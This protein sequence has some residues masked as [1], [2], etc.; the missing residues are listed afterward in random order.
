VFFEPNRTPYDLAWRMFG[1]PIRVHP[2]FWLISAA[3]GWNLMEQGF[4]FLLLW[5]ACVFV[6]VLVHELGH[7][8]LGRLFGSQGQIVLYSFG[9]LAIG[10][11]RLRARW[12]RI[13]VYLA[14][15]LAGFGLYVLAHLALGGGDREFGSPLEYLGLKFLAWINLFWGLLNLLPIWPLDGGQVSRDL[16]DGLMPEKGVRV[17]L[18]LSLV[19]A[20]VLAV[21]SLSQEYGHPL[22]PY[23]NYGGTFPAIFFGL[24]ALNSYQA[25]QVEAH[26]RPWDRS[27]ETDWR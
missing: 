25:L 21:H 10:S 5:V 11:S 9:G 13:A 19:V 27:D 20:G 12:Q 4:Q 17:A 26:H 7:A 18:G 23:L 15:P 14:G 22:I 6:S 8:L 3:M 16:L 2:L 24:L 1:I